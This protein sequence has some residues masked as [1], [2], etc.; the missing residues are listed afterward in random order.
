MKMWF[1]LQIK[2]G[3]YKGLPLK[4][5]KSCKT[6]TTSDDDD[7]HHLTSCLNRNKSEESTMISQ[8]LRLFNHTFSCRDQLSIESYSCVLLTVIVNFSLSTSNHLSS[9]YTFLYNFCLSLTFF[10]HLAITFFL[11][12]PL[13]LFLTNTTRVVDCFHLSLPLFPIS[14]ARLFFTVDNGWDETRKQMHN[15]FH[16]LSNFV[17]RIFFSPP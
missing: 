5:F 8:L 16:F 11:L 7:D 17:H 14:C 4:L 1:D 12:S 2:T 13:S 15:V 10:V 6:S 9:M 3:Q